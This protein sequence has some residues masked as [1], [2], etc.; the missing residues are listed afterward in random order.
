M[1]VSARIL[2]MLKLYPVARP[3]EISRFCVI[4]GKFA[5]SNH[6]CLS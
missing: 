4:C 1:D 6:V 3:N 2:D 5:V